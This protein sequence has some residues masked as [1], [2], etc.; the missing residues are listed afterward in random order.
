M[1]KK[2]FKRNRGTH[3]DFQ[4]DFDITNHHFDEIEDSFSSTLDEATEE[5]E[6]ATASLKRVLS[7]KFETGPSTS[8][9]GSPGFN[10]P[11]VDD[12]IEDDEEDERG[13]GLFSLFS[14]R[15]GSFCS[16]IPFKR[17]GSVLIALP[18]LIYGGMLWTGGKIKP[19]FGIFGGTLGR[20]VRKIGS[21]FVLKDEEEY[22]E[23]AELAKLEAEEAVAKK[24]AVRTSNPTAAK[25]LKTDKPG[26]PNPVF[27]PTPAKSTS[28]G[29]T[30]ANAV[31]PKND[32]V[33]VDDEEDFD[34]P[35]H[36]LGY[37]IKAAA[38]A[39]VLLLSVGGYYGAKTLFPSKSSNQSDEIVQTAQTSGEAD[40]VRENTNTTNMETA[41]MDTPNGNLPNTSDVP[42]NDVAAGVVPENMAVADS[43]WPA[44]S[45]S[46]APPN[47]NPS[48]FFAVAPPVPTQDD[49]MPTGNA[50]FESP[51][52]PSLVNPFD[53]SKTDN[54][55]DHSTDTVASE[56]SGDGFQ[57][58]AA[59]PSLFGSAMS[60]ETS[61][62]DTLPDHHLSNSVDELSSNTT[63]SDVE[64]EMPTAKND[65]FSSHALPI[66]TETSATDFEQASQQDN[67]QG[68]T[69]SASAA[70]MN[71]GTNDPWSVGPALTTGLTAATESAGLPAD[72][73]ASSVN[74]P[75][76]VAS[77]VPDPP[78]P[79]INHFAAALPPEN[80][81][82][83]TFATGLSSNI[84]D[85][86]PEALNTPLIPL[87]QSNTVQPITQT[88][89]P[90]STGFG[91]AMQPL[92]SLESLA[93]TSPPQRLGAESTIGIPGSPSPS[94]PKTAN[95]AFPSRD[96]SA[97]PTPP[98]NSF[99][100][101]NTADG[102]EPLARNTPKPETIP[103]IPSGDNAPRML[104]SAPVAVSS[105]PS[106]AA[107][108]LPSGNLSSGNLATAPLAPLSGLSSGDSIGIPRG[109]N[110]PSQN[111]QSSTASGTN[112]MTPQPVLTIQKQDTSPDGL[113][114]HQQTMQNQS[115]ED[116]LEPRLYFGNQD[117]DG[118][119]P[120]VQGQGAVRFAQSA[121]ANETST[122]L[123]MP[124]SPNDAVDN[125]LYD[126][127]PTGQPAANAEQIARSLPPESS[128]P[129]PMFAEIRPGYQ[130]SLTNQT[131]AQAHVNSSAVPDT[132][133]TNPNNQALLYRQRVEQSVTRTPAMME[134][135]TTKSG[136][137][138]MT[139]SNEKFGTH[140]LYRALAEH[141]RRLGVPYMPPEGTVIEIPTADYLQTNYAEALSRGA[142]RRGEQST[143][144]STHAIAAQRAVTNRQTSGGVAYTVQQ[145]DSVMSI[146]TNQLRDTHRWREI[147]ELNTDK[148]RSPRDLQPGMRIILPTNTASNTYGRH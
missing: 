91:E 90:L 113:Q 25:Q 76:A 32:L 98:T 73:A 43:G 109:D 13:P 81:T 39:G 129:E 97:A 53:V 118:Q 140:L 31:T 27:Q 125:L 29:K 70:S 26:Q 6:Q 102:I 11:L 77:S 49:T 74:N 54:T 130:R 133:S 37:A 45:A 127:N 59:S 112:F 108:R 132:S 56:E 50:S 71:D 75:F 134:R 19:I 9:A 146:A 145:G 148:I 72:L 58:S 92:Q 17:V 69:K 78:S 33:D 124:T 82:S 143:G 44:I 21:F 12:F 120:A 114:H 128:A 116:N 100:P 80:A 85:P 24:D 105:Q 47:E 122:L 119:H 42:S 3:G 94:H 23:D 40:S 86:S 110:T 123:P 35:S 52:A 61:S 64:T 7:E 2:E 46:A 111:L 28:S 89:A 8:D 136:D 65:T 51:P 57:V 18:M 67:G 131:P 103:M 96:F 88:S 93:P 41:D 106:E 147:I 4:E 84:A 60:A 55:V 142:R 34:G 20:A 135:Y 5:F 79:S 104:Y 99:Q 36:W 14:S 126:L 144:M 16:A 30:S 139:I 117:G 1:G 115:P 68:Q 15:I 66:A 95:E 87:N 62:N 121:R 63:V 138:Y 10:G 141:N 137:T 38:V 83:D 101:I 107:P 48:S 22:D